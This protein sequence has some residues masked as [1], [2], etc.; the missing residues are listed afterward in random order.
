M[1]GSNN[2]AKNCLQWHVQEFFLFVSKTKQQR[3]NQIVLGDNILVPQ[4]K[5]QHKMLGRD[6][7]I[8]RP[9]L[10]IRQL[11][12]KEKEKKKQQPRRQ[13]QTNKRKMSETK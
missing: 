3:T 1:P 13:E 9:R 12:K 11:E 5:L 10:W 6:M 8:H 4:L 7:R 2:T